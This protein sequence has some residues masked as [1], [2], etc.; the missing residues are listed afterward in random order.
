[1]VFGFP[2]SSGQLLT[3]GGV[4]YTVGTLLHQGSIAKFSGYAIMAGGVLWILEQL[5]IGL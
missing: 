1:M 2:I 3:Y 5:G 4:G